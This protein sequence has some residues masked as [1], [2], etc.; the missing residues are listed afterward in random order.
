VQKVETTLRALPWVRDVKVNF[1]AKTATIRV[2]SSEYREADVV[3]ALKKQGFSA[4]PAG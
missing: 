4:K 1:S 3:E 2:E